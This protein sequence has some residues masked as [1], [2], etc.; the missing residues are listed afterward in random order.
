MFGFDIQE[1][2]SSTRNVAHRVLRTLLTANLP[3]LQSQLQRRIKSAL[4]E[5]IGFSL[6]RGKADFWLEKL[7][8]LA[9]G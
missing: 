2:E 1:D 4:D 7:P 3:T 6:S 5:E 8:S 9:L